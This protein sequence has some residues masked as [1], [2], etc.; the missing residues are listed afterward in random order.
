MGRG[1]KGVLNQSNKKI[2]KRCG[3]IPNQDNQMFIEGIKPAIDQTVVD[4]PEDF[5][6][7]LTQMNPSVL[8]KTLMNM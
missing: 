3:L 2:V 6:N 8:A 1:R 4:L 7:E 5:L